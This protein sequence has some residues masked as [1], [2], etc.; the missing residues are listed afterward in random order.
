[1]NKPQQQHIFISGASRGLG[2][3]LA[4][5]YAKKLGKLATLSITA[6]SNENLK[7][8]KT[9][10]EALGC[11]VNSYAINVKDFAHCILQ[12]QSINQQYPIDIAILNSGIS[13]N[14]EAASEPWSQI[15]NIIETNLL[16]T[17]ATAQPLSSA[18]H[19]RQ[20]GKLVFIS[21]IAAHRGLAL[22]PSYCA[23]KA[24]IK[25]FAEALRGQ[26]EPAGV[27]VITVFPGFIT[28][29]MSEQFAGPKP[30]M[31]SAQQAAQ[32]IIHGVECNRAIVAFPW[33]LN[34]AQR[35]LNWLPARI[36]DRILRKMGYG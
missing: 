21:S 25:S 28:T 18:M 4:I 15:S 6:T 1:M 9:A 3:A 31:I 2:A 11:Q 23:S 27:S 34:L 20:C 8:T 14:S 13:G 16:G 7:Q 19:A 30:F 36:G 29:D 17:M 32:K 33:W 12:I 26:L 22:T 5:G 35:S 10:C 24:G